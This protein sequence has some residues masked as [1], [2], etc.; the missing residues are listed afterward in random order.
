MPIFCGSTTFQ[1]FD[2]MPTFN[3]FFSIHTD[4]LA[5]WKSYERFK[6]GIRARFQ[7][8]VPHQG[9]LNSQFSID[10]CAYQSVEEFYTCS[11]TSQRMSIDSQN[12]AARIVTNSPYDSPALPL[13]KSLGWLAIRE[14]IDFETSKMVYNC[15]NA[16]A[17]D[18]MR[19]MFQKVSEATNRQ[20]RNS[21]IDLIA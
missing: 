14:L 15:L 21:K 17:Q 16:L 18:Y 7:T 1:I 20:Q 13:I 10:V 5:V 6:T 19:N 12:R 3:F 4:Y 11:F 8:R 2:L 9:K